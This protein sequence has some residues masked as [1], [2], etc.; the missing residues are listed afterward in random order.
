MG[1]NLAIW[2]EHPDPINS[3]LEKSC[4]RFL[5]Q[6]RGEELLRFSLASRQEESTELE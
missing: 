3:N 1:K 5:G 2:A 4:R 6:E